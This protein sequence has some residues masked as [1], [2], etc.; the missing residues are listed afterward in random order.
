MRS[1]GRLGTLREVISLTRAG[2][3]AVPRLEGPLKL[4]GLQAGLCIPGAG[5]S[6]FHG[7]LAAA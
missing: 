6:V 4:D 1:I 5:H 7:S 3:I 2:P